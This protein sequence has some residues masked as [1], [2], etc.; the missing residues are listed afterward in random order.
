M[1]HRE[2]AL[3]MRYRTTSPSFRMK[4][5]WPGFPS[6]RETP[7]SETTLPEPVR[8]HF[9]GPDRSWQRGEQ[10]TI[11]TTSTPAPGPDRA[12]A[13]ARDTA[14]RRKG[15]EQWRS[16]PPIPCPRFGAPEGAKG[17]HPQQGRRRPDRPERPTWSRSICRLGAPGCR[18]VREKLATWFGGYDAPIGFTIHDLAVTAN[19]EVGFAY[20]LYRVTG[21]TTNGQPS[22]CGCAPLSGLVRSATICLVTHEHTSVP[23][24]AASGQAALQL[25][26]ERDST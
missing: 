8:L 10:E 9:P 12:T 26:P 7:L 4:G 18:R 23:F 1:D 24:D 21:K 25:T 5:S 15:I 17:P 22:T 2:S 11:C 13:L 3:L 20:Y 16:V 14:S 6:C 19:D